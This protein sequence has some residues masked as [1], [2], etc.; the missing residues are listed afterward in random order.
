[1][2]PKP[3]KKMTDSKFTDAVLA[4]FVFPDKGMEVAERFPSSRALRAQVA[5]LNEPG[6][7]AEECAKLA[8][9]RAVAI[10]NAHEQKM[11][12]EKHPSAYGG[13]WGMNPNFWKPAWQTKV[14]LKAEH[15]AAKAK[16]EQ[17]EALK[18]EEAKK[19]AH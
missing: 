10:E 6:K 12:A 9:D 15:A 16:W 13:C 14:M 3:T 2:H 1:M 17:E 18:A 7:T 11:R 8:Y 4:Q 5:E 19:A